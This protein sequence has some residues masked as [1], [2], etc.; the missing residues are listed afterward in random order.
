MTILNQKLLDEVN[1]TRLWFPARKIQCLWAKEVKQVQ[2]VTSLEGELTASVGDYLC[3]GVDGEM[4]PQRAESLFIKYEPTAEFDNAGWQKF[5]PRADAAGVM[6]AQISR[7]F[8]VNTHGSVLSGQ[9]NDYLVK[10]AADEQEEYPDDV[11]PVAQAIFER[12]YEKVGST[13]RGDN[14]SNN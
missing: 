10:Q 11:W 2:T 12:T 6:A 7:P 4:W 1:R 9:P 14:D 3:R 5:N 13:G 8:A